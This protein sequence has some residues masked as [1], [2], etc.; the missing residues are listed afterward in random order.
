MKR[1]LQVRAELSAQQSRTHCFLL[2]PPSAASKHLKHNSQL[3]KIISHGEV[4]MNTRLHFDGSPAPRAQ[5]GLCPCAARGPE[6]E[7]LPRTGC[8]AFVSR[9]TEG[10]GARQPL[11][12][13]CS[14]PP[15]QRAP[16][17]ARRGRAQRPGQR[18]QPRASGH[19]PGA[20]PRPGTG[21][22]RGRQGRA[23]QGGNGSKRR[24]PEAEGTT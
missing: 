1:W 15:G 5:S 4:L 9:G 14:P 23:G 22:A 24:L 3:P 11:H 7:G 12:R 13:C 6:A 18:A 19:S 21:T 17:A 10:W 20:A 8:A 16:G 2:I